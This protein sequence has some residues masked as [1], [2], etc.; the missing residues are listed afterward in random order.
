VGA[1]L[2]KGWR[3]RRLCHEEAPVD[4]VDERVSVGPN[5]N[6]DNLRDPNIHTSELGPQIIHHMGGVL[7]GYDGTDHLQV[8]ANE[9]HRV[10]LKQLANLGERLA[11]SNNKDR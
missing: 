1:V 7:Q 4:I 10:D 3:R 8:S 6:D 2:A 5:P 11:D 9:A